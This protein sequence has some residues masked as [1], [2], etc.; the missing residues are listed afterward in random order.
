MAWRRT[1][2]PIGEA[3]YATSSRLERSAEETAGDE[4]IAWMTAGTKKAWVTRRAAIAATIEAGS[5]ESSNTVWPPWK[6]AVSP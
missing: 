6:N 4:R 5:G 3:P 2:S 1:A